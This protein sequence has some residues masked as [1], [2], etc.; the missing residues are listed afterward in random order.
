MPSEKL[1]RPNVRTIETKTTIAEVEKSEGEAC[2][3]WYP[4]NLY[5]AATYFG[6]SEAE[7]GKLILRRQV[8]ILNPILP[9]NP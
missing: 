7:G 9:I 6:R 4:E 8:C 1:L 3:F 2:S 5:S